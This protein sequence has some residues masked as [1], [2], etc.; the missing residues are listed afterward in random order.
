MGN[1]GIMMMKMMITREKKVP[2]PFSLKYVWRHMYLHAYWSTEKTLHF[3]GLLYSIPIYTALQNYWKEETRKMYKFF[4][5]FS[6]CSIS[7]RL[8][9]YHML[10]I[11]TL[12]SLRFFSVLLAIFLLLVPLYTVCSWDIILLA[13][14]NSSHSRCFYSLLLLLLLQKEK[15]SI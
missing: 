4:V 11:S 13:E 12:I 15:H 6:L 14:H 3:P 10:N 5:C 8:A 1:G 9:S 7:S 2:K